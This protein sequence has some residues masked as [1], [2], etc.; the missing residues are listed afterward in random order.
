[1][2]GAASGAWPPRP[3]RDSCLPRNMFGTLL[4]PSPFSLRSA[5]RGFEGTAP[6]IF[7]APRPRTKSRKNGFCGGSAQE[8]PE[9]SKESPGAGSGLW[10]HQ[11]PPR[12][13]L[14]EGAASGAWPPR[15]FRDSCLP[16]NMFGAPPWPSPFSPPSAERGFEG[17]AP[18]IFE[19]RPKSRKNNFR[20]GSAQEPPEASVESP[21]GGSGLW[22]HQKPS[23]RFLVQGAASG[24][25]PP[26]PF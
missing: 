23:R 24:A 12:R 3:F 5:N 13:A 18:K 16:R 9:A 4:W 15:P 25:C 21:G 22:S 26:S 11:R 8:P 20:G 14:V 10:S 17:T 6:K 1:M 7:E 19:A 2:E